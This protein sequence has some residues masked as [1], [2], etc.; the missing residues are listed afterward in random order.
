MYFTD[1]YS[2]KKDEEIHLKTD[3]G[4]PSECLGLVLPNKV[5]FESTG[6]NGLFV[7]KVR[8]EDLASAT[9]FALVG[10]SAS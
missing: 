3:G 1:I 2:I 7:S 9:M 5:L 10:P 4:R 8:T 6:V